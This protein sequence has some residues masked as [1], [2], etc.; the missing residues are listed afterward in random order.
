MPA[1]PMYCDAGQ[2]KV[3]GKQVVNVARTDAIADCLKKSAQHRMNTFSTEGW[4]PVVLD[5]CAR[6]MPISMIA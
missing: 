2:P 1:T 6:H 5:T 3:L 4:T